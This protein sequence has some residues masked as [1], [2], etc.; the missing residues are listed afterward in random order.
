MGYFAGQVPLIDHQNTAFAIF[1]RNGGY[2][3]VLILRPFDRIEDDDDYVGSGNAVARPHDAIFVE[4]RGEFAGFPHAG[5]VGKQ[6]VSALAFGGYGEGDIDA[7][8]SCAGDVGD[9]D[10]VVVK[11]P[12]DERGFTGVR[13]AGDRDFDWLGFLLGGIGFWGEE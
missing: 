5:R 8:A 3:F 13:P 11:H 4:G 2:L 12:V 10:A 7:V 1:A 6:I 9:D